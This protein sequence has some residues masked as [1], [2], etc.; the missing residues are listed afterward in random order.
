MP[1]AS[2]SDSARESRPIHPPMKAPENL[3]RTRHQDQREHPGGYLGRLQH[4]KVGVE[5]GE[6]EEDR[7]EERSDHAAQLRRDPL[8][9]NRG[10]ADED[11]G[12]EGAQH[13]LDPQPVSDQRHRAHQHEDEADDRVFADK[14]I[15]DDTNRPRDQPAPDR[16]APGDEQGQRCESRSER[17]G[18]VGARAREGED[19]RDEEPAQRILEDRRRNDDLPEVPA[20]EVHVAHDHRK[21]LNRRDRERDAKEKGADQPPA[22]I[23]QQRRG[24]RKPERDAENERHADAH[25]RDADRGSPDP[26]HQADVGIHA[27]Q[28]QEQQ[29]A[30]IGDAVEHRLLRRAGRKDC[31]LGIWPN[32]ADER[33]SQQNAGNQLPDHGGLAQSLRCL[34]E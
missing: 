21:N 20:R 33:R 17:C 27:C 13:R 8:G 9:Q 18:A 14:V 31:M 30:E 34:A 15:V 10:L 25:H 28:Q 2:A 5:A 19:G 11:A 26:S 3:P 32:E 1:I 29:D 7:R 12:E 23:G 6:G 4:R 24:Q 16:Q 22:R